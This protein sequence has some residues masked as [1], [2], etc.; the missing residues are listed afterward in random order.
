MSM[1]SEGEVPAEQERPAGAGHGVALIDLLV[2]A[3]VGDVDDVQSELDVLDGPERQRGLADRVAGHLDGVVVVGPA[4]ADV[5]GAA[6]DLPAIE[7]VDGR[8]ETGAALRR[9][10]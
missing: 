3:R 2:V 6:A 1:R 10:R 4:L 7:E 5:D 9:A 8:P